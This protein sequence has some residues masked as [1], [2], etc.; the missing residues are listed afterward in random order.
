LMRIF[1]DVVYTDE[2]HIAGVVDIGN[3]HKI[4]HISANVL[5]FR[6]PGGK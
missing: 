1:A 5:I 4:A 6:G 2:Q 3:E